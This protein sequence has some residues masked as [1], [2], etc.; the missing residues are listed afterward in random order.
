MVDLCHLLESSA[1]EKSV[2]NTKAVFRWV[3]LAINFSEARLSPITDASGPRK[4]FTLEH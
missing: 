2:P 3:T 4:N 1:E